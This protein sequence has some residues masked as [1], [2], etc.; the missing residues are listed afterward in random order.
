[1]VDKPPVMTDGKRLNLIDSRWVFKRKVFENNKTKFKARLVIRGFKDRNMYG[2][3]ETYAPVSRLPIV[4]AV[5]TIINKLNLFALQLDVTTAFLNSELGDEEIYMKIPDGYNCTEKVRRE[6]VCRLKRALYGLKISPKKWN[7]KFTEVALTLGLVNDD[8]EPCLFTSKKSGEL[9]IL[10]LYVDDMLVASDNESRLNE[11]KMGLSKAF[12]LSDMGEP[13]SFL[14]MKIVR[15]RVKRVMTITQGDYTRKILN[16]FGFS[17]SKCHKTPIVVRSAERHEVRQQI[18]ESENITDFDVDPNCRINVPYREA[19]GSLLYL[20]GATRPDLA[21][22]VNV[23]SRNQINPTVHDWGRV[24]R[25]FRYLN[26][27]KDLGL[28]YVSDQSGLVAYSD[29]SFADCEGSVSTCGYIIR[30]YGDTVAWRT[31]KQTYVALSTCEAEYIAMAE[32]CREAVAFDLTLRRILNTSLFPI[33]LYC[34]NTAAERCATTSGQNK[35]RHVTEIKRDYVRECVREKR[36]SIHWISTHLQLAD[37]L[38]KPLPIQSHERL[39][40][41]I[42]NEP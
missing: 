35:L 23:L 38:T 6:K 9:V 1:L 39:R 14:G 42:L 7:E 33:I 12:K 13:N 16:R 19:V 34:D 22:A 41:A 30:L 11:I 29:A 8:R 36:I 21:Y 3:S 4:R 20:A 24:K 28:R 37:I 32:T 5:L 26:G 15:D 27:T 17:E 10:L 40:E 25:V 2:L 18:T 31:C